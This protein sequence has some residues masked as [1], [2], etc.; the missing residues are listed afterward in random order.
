MEPFEI[1][2]TDPVNVWNERLTYFGLDGRSPKYKSNIPRFLKKSKNVIE[3]IIS[4]SSVE[5]FRKNVEKT[6]IAYQ[7]FVLRLEGN[8]EDINDLKNFYV[9]AFGEILAFAVLETLGTLNVRLSNTNK[10]SPYK[11]YNVSP[12]LGKDFGADG[13]CYYDNN[14]KTTKCVVQVKFWNPY[15]NSMLVVRDAQAAR[16]VGTLFHYIN[17]DED[18]NVLFFWLGNDKRVSPMLKDFKELYKKLIFIDLET[19]QKS[20]DTFPSFWNTSLKNFIQSIT[21]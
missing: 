17:G 11:F 6:F 5:D 16:D 15:G 8:V 18:R 14:G 2:K 3:G 10:W 20:I 19:L 9:G 1:Y 21:G 12:I 4:V 13:T 7:D